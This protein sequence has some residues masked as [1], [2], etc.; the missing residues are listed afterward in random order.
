MPSAILIRMR[1][2]FA[3][4]LVF[5]GLLPVRCLFA[6]TYYVSQTTGNDSYAPTQ[7]TNLATPWQTIQQAANN[8]V[9]GDTVLIRAGT[10][11]ETVSVPLSGTSNAPITFEG[12]SNEV[13]V[14]SGADPATNW[15][16]ESSNIYYSTM[17]LPLGTGN[18]VFQNHLMMP[19]A[20]WP[21]A[22]SDFPWQNSQTNPSPDW[23]YVTTAGYTGGA[24]GWFTCSQ[25]PSETNGFWVGA[26]VH[27]MSGYGNVMA[28]ST[29]TGYTNSTKT[30]VTTDDNGNTPAY[31]I[32]AGNGFYLSGLKSLLDSP[33]EWWYDTVNSRLYFYSTNPPTNVEAKTRAV[34]FNLIQRA[35]IQ[36]VNLSFF[37]CVIENSSGSTDHVY[38][39]LT[40]KYISHFDTP[41]NTSPTTIDRVTLEDRTVLRNSD[42]GFSSCSMVYLAGS[43]IRVINNNLHDGGYIPDFYPLFSCSQAAQQNLISHNSI[44]DSGR[45]LLSYLARSSQVEYNDFSNAMRMASDGGPVYDVNDASPVLFDHNLLHD[46][47]GPVGYTGFGVCG[48]YLDSKT[49]GWI[50]HHNL[51]YNIPSYGMCFNTAFTFDGIFN[52]TCANCGNGLYSYGTQVQDAGTVMYNNLFSGGLTGLSWFTADMRY[53][54]YTSPGYATN[55]YELETNSIAVD[56]GVPVP[57]ITDGYTGAAPDLGAFEQ[58]G[59]DWT[60]QVGY[61]S[62]PPSPDPVYSYP[63]FI[64]A[65][66][67][68]DDGF[69]T[70]TLTNW[71]VAAGGS[72]KINSANAWTSLTS[73]SGYYSLSIGSGTSQVGQTLTNLLPNSH[74]VFYAGVF[75]SNYTAQVT[76]GVTNDGYPARSITVPQTN[77]WG[78]YDLDFVTGAT[79]TSACIYINVVYTSGTAPV[80][81]DDFGVI[82]KNPAVPAQVD[83]LAHYKLDETN[84]LTAYDSSGNNENATLTG[85]PA[86][87]W[88][89]GILNGALYL[90][91][92]DE[93]LTPSIPTSTNGLTIC[94]WANSS[95]ATWNAYGCLISRRPSFVLS[96]IMGGTELRFYVYP[97]AGT[98]VDAD[99]FPPAGFNIT[100]WHHYAGVFNAAAKQAILY[101][102]GLPVAWV[103]ASTIYPSSGQIYIGKDDYTLDNYRNFNGTIDDARIYNYALSQ[104]ALQTLA[105]TNNNLMMHLALDDSPGSSNAW[106]STGLD[107]NGTLVNMNVETAWTNGILDGAL[108]FDGVNDQVVTPPVSTAGG[109]TISC[110]AKSATPQWNASSCLIS[111][112]PAFV[113][114][115]IMGSS[116]LQF[117][118]Y[119]NADN[120][121]TAVWNAPTGFDITQWHE[122]AGVFDPTA[123]EATL[124]V[125]GVATATVASTTANSSTG[126]MFIGQ[127]STGGTNAN[128]GGIIDD[129]LLYS[130]PLQWN[131]MLNI[132][133][134]TGEPPYNADTPAGIVNFNANPING[135]EI[136]LAWAAG[137]SSITGYELFYRQTSSETWTNLANVAGSINTYTSTGLAPG[138]S[139]DYEIEATNAIAASGVVE[140]TTTTIASEAVTGTLNGNGQFAFS[141]LRTRSDVNYIVEC[142]TNLVTWKAMATNPGTVGGVVTVIEDSNANANEQFFRLV[143]TP[144]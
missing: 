132:A 120:Y 119:T 95:T 27:I 49:G 67:V 102:D 78:L 80:F 117:I 57:G 18:Q 125:D 93:L 59:V 106:D 134:A 104:S 121:V 8:V 135:S 15:V 36:L 113:L 126:Q 30:V 76:V 4:A 96:P 86:T 56:Q 123:Q 85:G 12:Y 14:V 29:V 32:T 105:T 73:R 82:L 21:N 71:T 41:F 60:S 39:G 128:F 2:F 17:S 143:I 31:A 118:L 25:L 138:V 130:R 115:P 54:L 61:N 3:F 9:P 141:F 55:G 97:T 19:L 131:E 111:D 100:Q 48:L 52:N 1:L 142:S 88:T 42:L 5:S 84:G 7:A 64:F 26:T 144:P 98:L 70:G 107:G 53:N 35:F 83:P 20:R 65:N 46:S 22:G 108:S 44:H 75:S 112:R 139:Y 58:G 77:T 110:W 13:A 38:D 33:G 6:A 51:I 40:M 92:T 116:N 24:N 43:N 101:V 122:Y 50:A 63:N 109:F 87:S 47:P 124:Y 28:A 10:Y 23:A 69:E 129:V 94:C 68:T 62:T 103:A 90:N 79:N 140:A 16:M 74:Y 11:R 89:N 72:A 137:N 127:D 45:A 81:A 114:C 37:G 136:A 66:Q 34:G 91:G 133:F 99:W